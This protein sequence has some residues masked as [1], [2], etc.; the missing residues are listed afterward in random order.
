MLGG[1]LAVAALVVYSPVGVQLKEAA[2]RLGV[3]VED[4]GG[5]FF[6]CGGVSF[7]S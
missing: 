3:A 7:S 5:V 1:M 6:I 4:G 2:L